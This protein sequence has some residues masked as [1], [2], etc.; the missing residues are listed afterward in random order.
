[1][2][3]LRW[4]KTKVGLFGDPKVMAMLGQRHGDTCFVIWFLLK[5]IA[6]TVNCD[7]YTC[8]SEQVP[9]TCEYI[10]RVLRRHRD[11][12]EKSL[13]FLE[14]I[15]LVR[16]DEA[17][18]IRLVDWE[19]LQDFDK[20]ERRRQQT[21]CR[22]ARFRQKQGERASTADAGS[23]AVPEATA[24]GEAAAYYVHVFGGIH[25]AVRLALDAL[26]REWGG[27]AVC[28]AVDIAREQGAEGNNL[29]YIR[30]ILVNS[31]GQPRRKGKGDCHGY[32]SVDEY[33]SIMLR[34]AD[35]YESAVRARSAE[36]PACRTDGRAGGGAG[37][38]PGADL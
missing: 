6:G 12:V 19:E 14:Q 33:V 21:R 34:K 37:R 36:K 1:M 10:A 13:D 24:E 32:A 28:R 27:D 3:Q 30:S 26:E 22:V 8:L 2:K 17:G 18:R 11:V 38:P 9:L 23:A 20:D 4:M 25:P 29:N 16:R 5:D 35:E 31:G 7:G 15:D